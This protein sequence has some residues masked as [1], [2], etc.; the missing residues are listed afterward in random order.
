M[1]YRKGI[2]YFV[3]VLGSQERTKDSLKFDESYFIADTFITEMENIQKRHRK[4]SMVDR[5]VFSFSDCAYIVY[6]LKDEF[7]S[8]ENEMKMI[9]TSLY[10]TQ[11]TICTFLYNGFLCRGGI[12]FGDVYHDIT[13]NIVFGP[14]V[15]N[16]YKLESEAIYPNLIFQDT[17]SERLVSYDKELKRNNEEAALLNGN[18][19]RYNSKTKK[20]FLNYLNYFYN[21]GSASLGNCA[22]FHDDFYLKSMTLCKNTLETLD[23]EHVKEKYRWQLDYL[24]KE[25]SFQEKNCA[26]KEDILDLF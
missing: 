14:A 16:A 9:Y 21:T 5:S 6:S 7:Q 12:S 19:V 24:E 17:L 18:I 1:G 10:N 22:V 2:V 13:R 4:T 26:T 11:Q 25:K 15:N 23:D 3:D 8:Y 20:F